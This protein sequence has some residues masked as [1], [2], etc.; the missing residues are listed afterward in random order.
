MIELFSSDAEHQLDTSWDI[1]ATTSVATEVR[2]DILNDFTVGVG[3]NLIQIQNR[4]FYR[5]AS[6]NIRA[7]LQTDT[8]QIKI[9]DVAIAQDTGRAEFEQVR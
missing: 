5:R 8:S 2:D 1:D 9:K 7:S 3:S 6:L 4:F